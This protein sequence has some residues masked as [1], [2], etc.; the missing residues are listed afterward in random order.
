MG[1]KV[2]DFEC[3]ECETLFDDVVESDTMITK[4][5]DCGFKA[6]MRTDTAPKLGF[7][8]NR[9][10]R[11]EALKKR[12][13]EHTKQQQKAGNIMGPKDVKLKK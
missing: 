1:W 6:A 11:S 4:C 5:K 10:I 7:M 13:V 9:E 3:P 12:S 8:N 2:Y